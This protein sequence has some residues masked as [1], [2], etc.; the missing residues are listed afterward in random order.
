MS[1][2]MATITRKRQLSIPAVVARKLNLQRGDKVPVS[3]SE[4]EPQSIVL[5]PVRR[6]ANHPA[7]KGGTRR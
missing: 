2:G 6:I 1:S 5:T 4:G 7:R 3:L